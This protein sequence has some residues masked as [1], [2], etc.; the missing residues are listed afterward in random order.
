MKQGL[1]LHLNLGKRIL[2]AA[3]VASMLLPTWIGMVHAQ[4]QAPPDWQAA[5]GGKMAF[6]V[7]SVKLDK[8]EARSPLF[9][10]DTGR[11]YPPG[12][13]LSAAVSVVSY[14]Q[15]AYKIIFS[16]RQSESILDRFPKWLTSD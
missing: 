7:A 9:P 10:L 6:E 2:G 16:Q 8:G 13:R 5:A 11:R 3:A 15:F 4:S 14:I 1:G 12:N